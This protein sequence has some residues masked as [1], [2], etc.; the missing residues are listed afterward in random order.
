M[1]KQA[2]IIRSVSFQQLDRNLV[3]IG[4]RF[5]SRGDG[6]RLHLLTHSHGT[7]RA[8]SYSDIEEIID[9][10]SLK[11]FSFFHVPA[12]LKR[13][14]YDAVIVPVTNKSGVGFLNVLAMTLRIKCT[15]IYI[16]NLTS[17]IWEITRGNIRFKAVRAFFLSILAALLALP[18]MVLAVP[19]LL[20]F[21]LFKR[22]ER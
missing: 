13:E 1:T 9:Y 12:V 22:T 2:L 19:V 17:D 20:G 3:A 4:K 6:F 10:G 11:N 8:R 21:T 5:G 18:G 7:G 15:R 14:R 16:C